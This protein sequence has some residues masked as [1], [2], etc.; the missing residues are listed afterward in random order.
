MARTKT[1]E[2]IKMIPALEVQESSVTGEHRHARSS[3]AQF[4]VLESGY[5]FPYLKDELGKYC[6]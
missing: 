5:L 1:Q 6:G 4:V 3:S 2:P